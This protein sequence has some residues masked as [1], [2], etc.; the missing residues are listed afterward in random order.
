[1]GCE[2]GRYCAVKRY[3]YSGIGVI[4]VAALVFA[5]LVALQKVLG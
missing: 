5:Y 3:I 4:G 2:P 1:M